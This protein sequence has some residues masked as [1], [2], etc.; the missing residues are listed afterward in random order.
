MSRQPEE[1][2]LAVLTPYQQIGGEAAVRALVKRFYGHM[3]VNPEAWSVRRMHGEDLSGS[4][5]KLF[6]FLSG[7]LGGPDLYV[8]RY[9]PPFLR[10]RHLPFAIGETERDEWLDCMRR[11]LEE[12]VA[13]V[14][15]RGKLFQSFAALANH[16]RNRPEIPAG[17]SPTGRNKPL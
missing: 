16:M 3:D 7:W 15:L 6:L 8:Q 2:T 9:G 13:D 10:A 1:A 5:E 14:A 11:A 12:C 17:S 4:E